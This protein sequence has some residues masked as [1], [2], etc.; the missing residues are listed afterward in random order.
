MKYNMKRIALI[1]LSMLSCCSAFSQSAEIEEMLKKRY[2]GA[3]VVEQSMNEGW[4]NIVY[5]HEKPNECGGACDLQGKEIIAPNKYTRV[6]KSGSKFDGYYYGVEIGDKKGACDLNGKEII[7]CQFT[8]VIHSSKG[9]FR[10]QT[11]EGGAYTDYNP[12]NNYLNPTTFKNQESGLELTGS[13][14]ITYENVKLEGKITNNQ[15]EGSISGTPLL[16]VYMCTAPYNGNGE[17]TGHLY[18]QLKTSQ[19][20]GGYVRTID[21]KYINYTKPTAGT[22]YT[23]LGL[24]EYTSDNGYVLVDY[25]NFDGQRTYSNPSPSY[26]QPVYQQPNFQQDYSYLISNYQLWEN[27]VKQNWQTL[28]RMESGVARQGILQSYVNGQSQMRQIRSEA[29]MHG[30]TIQISPWEN[31]SAPNPY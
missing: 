10:V 3:L 6:Y 14:S 7:P 28:S 8:S 13:W 19:I 4:Y 23:V 1:F 2:P 27:T 5:N 25:L 9:V 15:A 30:I 12:S 31:A 20:K 11:Y 29:T 16:K 17:L 22:Y 18:C 24:Y 26:T 21:E